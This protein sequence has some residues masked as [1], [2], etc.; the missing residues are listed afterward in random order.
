[1]KKNDAELTKKILFHFLR[2]KLKI[3]DICEYVCGLHVNA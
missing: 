2:E 1:M 3:A